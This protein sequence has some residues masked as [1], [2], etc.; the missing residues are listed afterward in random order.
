MILASSVTSKIRPRNKSCTY[1]SH[2]VH[3]I[4][5]YLSIL[6][7]RDLMSKKPR[8]SQGIQITVGGDVSGQVAAGQ[9]INQVSTKTS[10]EVTK[11]DWEEFR[12]LLAALRSK[13]EVEAQPDKKEAAL[14]RV[15]E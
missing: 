7:W 2:G 4:A 11:A 15:G 5:D 8:P 10:V 13:I 14:E 9:N 3:R 1:D 12:Q 6:L